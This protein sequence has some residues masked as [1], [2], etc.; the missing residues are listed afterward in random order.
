MKRISIILVV[1]LLTLLLTGC[2]SDNIA[3]TS[4]ESDAIAQY[5]A[6]LLLKYDKNKLYD[7]KL[8]DLDD[9]KKAEEAKNPVSTVTPSL[10][11]AIMPSETP[12]DTSTVTPAVTPVVTPGYSEGEGSDVQTTDTATPEPTASPYTLDSMF[13]PEDI[14]VSYESC[15]FTDKYHDSNGTLDITAKDNEHIL[16]MNIRIKNLT[17]S[18]YIFDSKQ[19]DIKYQLKSSSGKS[20]S[21]AISLL[22]NDIQFFNE[23]EIKA[24]ESLDAILMFFVNSKDDKYTLRV[25]GDYS[26]KSSEKACDININ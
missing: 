15:E 5:C 22:S 7:S 13:S 20:F 26:D 3:L 17:S 25:L 6:H 11:P 24:G 1:V 19:F 10:T 8:M 21:P 12:A 16:V 9:F 2:S 18:V 23:Q 14:H 4:E